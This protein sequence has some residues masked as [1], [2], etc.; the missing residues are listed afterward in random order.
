MKRRTRDFL[1]RFTALP[2]IGTYAESRQRTHFGPPPLPH[3]VLLLHG[4]SASPGAFAAL[5][6]ALEERGIPYH[7]PALTGFGLDD[8]R[9]LEAVRASDW[10]RD[11]LNGYDVVAAAA[12]EV[13]VVGLSY[14]TLLAGFVAGERPVKHLVLAAPYFFEKATGDQ[15]MRRTLQ[16]PLV[17]RLARRLGLYVAKPVRPGRATCVDIVD[18]DEARA[19]FQY[20]TL[21]L[22]SLLEVWGSPRDV[23]FRALAFETLD[24]VAGEQEQTSDVP[25]FLAML[26][27]QGVPYRAH[28]L[29]RTAHNVFND[30]DKAEAAAIVADILAGRGAPA[31]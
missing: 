13:S 16:R 20:P 23:D 26:D 4:F 1:A 19:F 17:S 12:R 9:L 22:S 8:L 30:H 15:A 28:P 14:G 31:T 2:A 18:P 5:T 3:A 7:A 25:A 29:A 27:R 6:A 11:A 21:P 24:V 10:R